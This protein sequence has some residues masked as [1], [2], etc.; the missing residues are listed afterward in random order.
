MRTLILLTSALLISSLSLAQTEESE[1]GGSLNSGTLE[2]QYNY[3]LNKSNRY[4]KF[5]VIK[6][7]WL[8]T[9]WTHVADT[10]EL[11]HNEIKGYETTIAAQSNTISDLE[12][13]LGN[14]NDS[15][16]AVNEEKDSISFLGAQTDKGLYKKVMWGIAMGLLALLLITLFRF[17]N[18][19]SITKSTK[20]RL[21]EIESEFDAHK[22]RSLEKEQELKR[23]LQ[24]HINKLDAMN[25][26]R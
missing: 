18:S 19:K 5:K 13:S 21:S 23:E 15:L 25:P 9:Y 10:L 1:E 11:L 22:R 20:A 26:P 12:A 7:T 14:A 2:Q 16:G 4:K 6:K 8:N 3:M 24:D 17:R